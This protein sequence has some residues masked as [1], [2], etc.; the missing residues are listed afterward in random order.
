MNHIIG[1]EKSKWSRHPVVP[2]SGFDT[3]RWR[4]GCCRV[5][6][7]ESRGVE[8]AARLVRAGTRASSRGPPPV[9]SAFPTPAN[10]AS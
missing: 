3:A 5:E 7:G 8:V 9:F 10:D 4:R 2:G 1:M 6:L